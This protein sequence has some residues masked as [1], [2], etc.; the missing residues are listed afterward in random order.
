ML[1]T[2]ALV[3]AAAFV[4]LGVGS[5]VRG[6]NGVGSD[7]RLPALLSACFLAYSFW[8][9]VNEGPLGFW[10]NHTT[11][12]WGLQ[13]WFD[14]LLAASIA[15]TALLPRMKTVGMKVFPWFLLVAATG[16]IGLLAALSRL[17]FLE[18][19]RR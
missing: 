10:P 7:W 6:G 8:T 4:L 16:S 9:V 14:L 5:S 12:L 18:R 19:N 11:N 17:Q 2:M 13:V 15:W 1:S 3:G